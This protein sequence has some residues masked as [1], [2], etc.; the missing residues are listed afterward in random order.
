MFYYDRL[1]CHRMS[2]FSGYRCLAIIKFADIRTEK[3]LFL[4]RKIGY[5]KRF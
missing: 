5:T 1:I 3:K 2:T 4:T